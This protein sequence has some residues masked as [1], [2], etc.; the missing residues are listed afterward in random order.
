MRAAAGA[1]PLARGPLAVPILVTA[2]MFAVL[3][4]LGVWQLQ[5]LQWKTGL[6]AQIDAA[7]AAPPVPLTGDPKPFTKV[8]VH[9]VLRDDAHAWY[10]DDVRDQPSGPAMG[11]FLIEPL[12]RPGQDPVLVDRG[13]VP[14][15]APLPPGGPG[16][17]VGYVRAPDAPGL[18]SAPDD[19]AARHFYT[20]DPVKIGAALGLPRVAPLTLIA[21]GAPAPGL[22]P[23]TALPRPPNDHLNYA[24][25]WFGL[26]VSLLAVFGAY[27]RKVLR[28]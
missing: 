15:G 5:R 19:L 17:A 27:L 2:V 10:G 26:A 6:L 8:V 23:A 1:A 3:V 16:D 14:N 20:L 9:G 22:Q 24:L 25:T 18:F 21:M 11:A 4:G 13:W 28:S 12:E 7:E